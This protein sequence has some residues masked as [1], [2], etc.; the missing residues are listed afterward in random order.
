MLVEEEA[1]TKTAYRKKKI[2]ACNTGVTKL[3]IMESFA[4]I[5]VTFPRF[6]HEIFAHDIVR[7]PPFCEVF[8]TNVA[9]YRDHRR[10]AA[11]GKD[12][13]DIIPLGIGT[14]GVGAACAGDAHQDEQQQAKDIQEREAG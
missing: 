4:P 11:S 1:A 14:I 2:T 13:P 10:I 6:S 12:I 7:R 9:G 5:S 8:V 3:C